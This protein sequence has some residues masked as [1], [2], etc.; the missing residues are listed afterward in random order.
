[1]VKDSGVPSAL[2]P[3]G[4]GEIGDVGGIFFQF[5]DFFEP[6]RF[7]FGGRFFVQSR[8]GDGGG[9]G[10]EHRQNLIGV[11]LRAD[12]NVIVITFDGE[13]AVQ[14]FAEKFPDRFVRKKRVGEHRHRAFLAERVERRAAV[15]AQFDRHF[16]TACVLPH[17]N[18][19]VVE[20][21]FRARI[22]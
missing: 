5:F 21:F 22:R 17:Q 6:R 9:D 12:L 3:Y 13:T 19:Q 1:M 16:I 7:D 2:L 18:F 15:N 11:A 10:F 8:F 14:I 4:D 20:Q